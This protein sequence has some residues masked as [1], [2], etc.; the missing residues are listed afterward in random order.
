MTQGLGVV[1]NPQF[2]LKRV[3]QP[4]KN[5]AKNQCELQRVTFQSG[6]RI[7]VANR[8]FPNGI[9]AHFIKWLLFKIG[10][11]SAIVNIGIGR[12]LR[13]PIDPQ[14]DTDNAASYLLQTM[15]G[16]LMFIVGCAGNRAQ[17]GI[18]ISTTL[19]GVRAACPEMAATGG[20]HG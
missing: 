14:T 2:G 11:V 10:I 15:A 7:M 20:M 9:N 19:N 3:E 12:I 16:R 17:Q 5:A 4:A 18:F 1:A 13:E 6:L 8:I